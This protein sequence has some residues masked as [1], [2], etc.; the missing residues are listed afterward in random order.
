[1]H[2]IHLS[3]KNK[4]YTP[5]FP[6]KKVSFLA[7][8]CWYKNGFRENIKNHVR[9][10]FSSK[11]FGLNVFCYSWHKITQNQ[12]RAFFWLWYVPTVIYRYILIKV[13]LESC[14]FQQRCTHWNSWLAETFALL[15]FD[16]P[17]CFF[18]TAIF[19]L[20]MLIICVL[21]K[22]KMA[23]NYVIKQIIIVIL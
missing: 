1:M 10:I 13:N 9:F 23:W 14:F 21:W 6:S 4:S 2:L 3:L 19:L 8:G 7:I 12:S 20:T 17:L 15:T 22:M 16:M 18:L 11:Q 5:F